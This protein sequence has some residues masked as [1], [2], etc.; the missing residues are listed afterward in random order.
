MIPRNLKNHRKYLIPDVF[1]HQSWCC[2]PQGVDA[3][4][5]HPPNSLIPDPSPANKLRAAKQWRAERM[6]ASFGRPLR[7]WGAPS[8]TQQMWEELP[9]AQSFSWLHPCIPNPTTTPSS[10]ETPCTH[11]PSPP[12]LCVH[13][14]A[15]GKAG[16]EQLGERMQTANFNRYRYTEEL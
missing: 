3:T 9:Q 2:H 16:E 12:P 6:G 1:V 4:P 10:R 14:S 5:E 11:P 7:E 13:S 8:I 15:L